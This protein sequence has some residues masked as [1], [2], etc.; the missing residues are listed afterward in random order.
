MSADGSK[1]FSPDDIAATID[2]TILKAE[3]TSAQIDKLCDEAIEH[4]FF[5][6]C[7]NGRYVA[8]AASRI[9]GSSGFKPAI[10]AVVG[11]PLGAMSTDI[12]AMEA[13]RAMDDGATEIDMVIPVGALLE[14][15]VAA[16]RRDIEALAMVVHRASTPG[17]LKVILETGLLSDEQI[18]LGCRASAEGEADFVKTSTGMHASGGATIPHVQLLYRHATP[19][20]VKASGGIRSLESALAMI[21]AGASRI[22]T[23]SGVAILEAAR[24]TG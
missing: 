3:A 19:I 4:R 24:A 16:V 9:A 13:Q 1:A 21:E 7:V 6:V 17:L 18:Q 5:A 12:K 23:S 2:H 22:G 14:G 8:R 20:K 10:A 15:D 11:F